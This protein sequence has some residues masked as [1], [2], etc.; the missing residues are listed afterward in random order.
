MINPEHSSKGRAGEASLVGMLRALL[1]RA[2]GGVLV[3]LGLSALAA[4]ALPTAALALPAGRVYEMVSP[5][6]KGGYGANLIKGVA[7]DGE[8]VAFFSPG[9]FAGAPSG[10]I[11]YLARRGP[12][13]WSTTP[14][15]PAAGL[16]SFVGEMDVSP[17]LESVLAWGKPGPNRI[18]ATQAGTEEEF[19]LHST[20]LP[21][22][23]S[24]W[25]VAGMALR[26]L[27]GG[28]LIFEYLGGSADFCHLLFGGRES[29]ILNTVLPEAVNTLSLYELAR[30]CDGEPVS[31]H[32]VG[33]NNRGKPIG[34]GTGV[35]CPVSLGHEEGYDG[36]DDG[37]YNAIA[38]DGQEVF[39]TSCVNSEPAHY[40]VFV[41]LDASRTLEVSRPLGSACTEVPCG[42][43]AAA[44]ARASADFVGASEDGSRVF[45][46][47]KAPLVEGDKD[48]DDD[49]YMA[50]ISCPEAEPECGVAKRVVKSL[51]QVSHAPRVGEAAEVQGVVAVAPDGSRAYF[52]ARGVLSEAPNAQGAVAVR[53]A[54]NLY[55]Y[56]A[57]SGGGTTGDVAFVGQ[58]CS[59]QGISGTAA[60]VRCPTGSASDTPLWLSREPEAQTA[61]ADGRFLV[62]S[63][64]AQLTA[65]DT[66]RAQD[67]YWYDA[68]TGALE[69]VSGGEA[70]A[71]ANGNNDLFNASIAQGHRGGGKVRYQHEMDS[72]AISEDGSRVVFTSSEPLSPAATNGLANVYEWH[73]QSGGG[74]GNVSLISGGS[75]EGPVFSA[76]I[77]ASGN[78]V[79]FTT[80]QSLVAQDTD[81][82]L[83]LYDA[84]L[85]GGFP[86]TPAPA[87]ACA[88]DACQGP[89]TNPAALLI[90]GSI[91]QAPGE[92]LSVSGAVKVKPRAKASKC[93]KGK[94]LRGG[95][96]AK[97]KPKRQAKQSNDGKEAGNRA[98]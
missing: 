92:N 58:L 43:G 50:E 57:A 90:P 82:A 33:V 70:G 44:A 19:L 94:K 34:A 16:L 72:R 81:E 4:G 78:D 38:D 85:N 32:L 18:A 63:T 28:P 12:S 79:F 36:T 13:G 68:G 87:K 29:N 17:S 69:R 52:V 98:H 77:A 83:D 24:T 75:A 39:F 30:G 67:V 46:T 40:Q 61:G 96:C 76:V 89:L 41:R 55:A 1:G 88:D 64:Y 97:P 7:A 25:E 10:P 31:L 51:Q 62:F 49:L 54:D 22:I 8:A 37:S 93:S 73:E 80:T 91:S 47:T 84:R 71:D 5:V 3:A 60:D 95:K 2:G 42:G 9:A 23:S 21:D 56:T 53:G 20:D 66:D 48:Q 45:F 11:D 86:A 74:E 26:N 15:V 6:Y 14:L 27:G 59:G 35:S 65:S